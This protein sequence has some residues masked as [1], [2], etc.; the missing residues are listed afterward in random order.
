MII[1]VVAVGKTK[2][3]FVKDGIIE[4]EKRLLKYGKL[5]WKFVEA[6]DSKIVSKQIEEETSKVSKQLEQGVPVIVLDK[7]GIQLSSEQ[8]A[9][10]LQQYERVGKIQVV[11]G[12]SHGIS[13]PLLKSDLVVSFSKMTFEHDLVRLLLLEQLYRA[14]DISAGGEYH[15]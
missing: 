12:G 1:T 15:K 8:L 10:Q 11:I 4:Y 2:K 13:L 14:L 9:E 6:S 7:S 3:D 5:V